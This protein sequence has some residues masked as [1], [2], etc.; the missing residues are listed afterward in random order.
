MAILSMPTDYGLGIPLSEHPVSQKRA[1]GNLISG[2]IITVGGVIILIV[3]II[4]AITETYSAGVCSGAGI[5]TLLLG[6]WT[7]WTYQREK[8][9]SISLYQDGLVYVHHNKT[10]IVRWDVINQVE[11]SI[12]YNR[13][14][15]S[16]TYSYKLHMDDGKSVSFNYA[17]GAIENLKQLSDTIQHQTSERLLVK[18]TAEFNAG[19]PV[20]FGRLTASKEGLRYG[21]KMVLW[22]EVEDVQ[23]RKGIVTVR[24]QGKHTSWASIPVAQ[25]SNIFVLMRLVHQ[26]LGK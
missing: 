20:V 4:L 11:M 25:I 15:R 8:N 21:N 16:S 14:L 22:S 17:D 19:M 7:V 10:D 24:K 26:I 1:K 2:I 6:I 9:L 12:F 3:S 18:A 23:L 5:I 13:K